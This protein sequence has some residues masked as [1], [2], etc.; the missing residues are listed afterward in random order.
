MNGT[1]FL[2]IS[3]QNI[4]VNER[5]FILNLFITVIIVLYL[6]LWFDSN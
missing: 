3:F 6:I 4:S 2:L 1:Q 5:F